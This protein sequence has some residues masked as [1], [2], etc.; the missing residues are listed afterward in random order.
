VYHAIV[1]RRAKGVF[2]SVS[3]ADFQSVAR[4]VT[5]DVHHVFAGDHA[6]G[7]E[8]HTK[9]ALER[10]FARLHRLF[11]DLRFEV[12][13]VVAKGWPWR[14]VVALE[15]VAHGTLPNGEPYRNTGAH[16]V[17]M[18]WGRAAYIHAYEDSQT[19]A[20]ACRRI[21]ASGIEEG[22]APPITS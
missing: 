4:Q 18:R 7:G 3:Q 11:P 14:T 15:W 2:A 9:K 17:R 8:R 21:A 5:D 20:E 10:W 12:G 6:L 16:V 22:A 1:R 13:E 19:V